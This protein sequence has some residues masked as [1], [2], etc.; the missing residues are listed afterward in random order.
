MALNESW[1]SPACFYFPIAPSLDGTRDVRRRPALHLRPMSPCR[2]ARGRGPPPTNHNAFIDRLKL[3]KQE[4]IE[5]RGADDL[6][7]EGVLVRPLD[8]AARPALPLVR[9]PH[10]DRTA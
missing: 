6:R 3:A 5:W 10:G 1:A 7:I 2:H 4:G 9:S 8:G